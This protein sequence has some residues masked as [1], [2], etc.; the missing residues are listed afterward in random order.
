MGLLLGFTCFYLVLLSFTEFHLGLT[1]FYWVLPGFIGFYWGFI[2]FYWVLP[3]FAGM[4]I[5]MSV[6]PKVHLKSEL[7][8]LENLAVAGFDWISLISYIE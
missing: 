5:K 1:G 7:D 3:S 4:K 2:G 8:D 6:K